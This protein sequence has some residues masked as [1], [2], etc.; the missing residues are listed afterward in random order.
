MK[1]FTQTDLFYIS[2]IIELKK[3]ENTYSHFY[4]F[5]DAQKIYFYKKITFLL[6]LKFYFQILI[7]QKQKENK[8]SK[9]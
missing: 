5:F 2:G 4:Y 7:R 9:K 6:K 8:K 3:K 1:F